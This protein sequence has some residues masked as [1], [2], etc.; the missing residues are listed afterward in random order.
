MNYSSVESA[1]SNIQQSTIDRYSA[2]WNTIVPFTLRE[3]KERW[4]FAF[5][6]IRS[7]WKAN[8]DAFAMLAREKWDSRDELEAL[9]HKS[10]IGLVDRRCR[11]IWEFNQKFDADPDRFLYNRRRDMRDVRDELCKELYGIGMAKV[12]FSFEMCYPALCKVV[13]IDTHIMQMYGV[14]PKKGLN[15]RDY[16]KV[17]NHWLNVCADVGY[18]SAIARHILW[19]R[20]QGKRSNRYWTHVLELQA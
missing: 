4:W 18:P 15:N 1:I 10:R 14:D 19:D 7:G 3:H 13:C 6:S 2:Y 11:A 16:R 9:L 20:R 5:L 8:K 17:E 12:A